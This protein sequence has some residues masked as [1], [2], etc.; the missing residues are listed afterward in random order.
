[1][2]SRT[3]KPVTT[4][5][6]ITHCWKRGWPESA[7]LWAFA[8]LLCVGI[9]AA[10]AQSQAEIAQFRAERQDEEIFVSAEVQ[11]ELPSTVEDALLRGIPMYFLAELDILR[12]RWYWYDKK[13]ATAQRSMRLAYQPLTRTWRVNAAQGASVAGSQGLT[14]NQSFE[15]LR[16]ALAVIKRI[17]RWKVAD[18]TDLDGGVKH[19]VDFRF[20]LD[21]SQLP[22]PFQIGALGQT[23]WDIS[24][25]LVAPLILE[26]TK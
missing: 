8:I 12:D 11:F 2:T 10:Q 1:V 7:I 21:L 9:S 6:S 15:N 25:N 4:M 22:R 17:S 19:H 26:S 16:Q 3:I 13:V 18:T 5:A 14:L 23:G 24:A 20:K